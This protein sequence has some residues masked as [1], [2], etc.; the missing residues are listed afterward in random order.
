MIEEP[1]KHTKLVCLANSRIPTEKAHGYQIFKM[2]E[3]FT[4][5]S[6]L[7]E[8][9]HPRRKNTPKMELVGNVFTYYGVKECFRLRPLPCWDWWFLKLIS[10]RA[11]ALTQ[12]LSFA[13][14]ALREV[15]ALDDPKIGLYTRNLWIALKLA[16]WKRR[17]RLC[18][19]V[20]FEAH[21]YP[22]GFRRHSMPRI[23]YL[24]GII[25]IT[26]ALRDRFVKAGM[27]GDKVLVAPDG[28]DLR[29]YENM[30]NK[31]E[32]R[33]QLQLPLENPLIIYT[34]HFY[35]WKGVDTLVNSSHLLEKFQI[36]LVGGME[37]DQKRVNRQI[38]EI[39]VNN[40]FLAGYKPPGQIPLYL[41]AAD[42]L[43]LPN[44][45]RTAI[46][47]EYTSPLKLF[48]YMAAKRPIVAT[49]LPSI[50]EILKDG[51]NAVLVGP[52]DPGAL[53]EGIR[54]VLEDTELAA[55][56]ADHAHEDVKEYTWDKR[57]ERILQFMNQ[58]DAGV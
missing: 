29:S 22:E 16:E 36:I 46:S 44:S 48:E 38:R 23:K 55:S 24:D 26:L 11:W 40:V 7:V 4:K 32:A 18:N 28:V 49:D 9:W 56:I 30:P 17:N 33:R 21:S 54:R 19:T 13:V 6:G 1:K 58:Q 42:V 41:A 12:V 2:C 8:F 47:R 53:A 39:G 37:E 20:I 52:D 43:V 5:N 15:R 14:N 27:S 25:V 31:V 57:S 50:R 34:G 10:K 51:R 45:A 35:N 3:A